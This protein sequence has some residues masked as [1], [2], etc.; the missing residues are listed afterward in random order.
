MNDPMAEKTLGTRRIFEGR[1]LTIDIVDIELPTGRTS[2]REILRHHG[3]VCILA[4]RPDGAF[5]LVNQY[6]KAVEKTLLECV[7]GCMEPGESPDSAALRETRE[8]SGYEVESLVALGQSLPAPGYC[9]EVHY[10]FYARLKPMAG[11]LQLDTDENLCPV[12]LTAEAIDSA[13]EDGTIDDGKTIILWN[14]YQRA[15]RRGIL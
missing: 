15:L 10:H 7:A 3:A 9:D 5:I 12:A 8:E 13:I 2:T 1:A 4:Q 6:R 14:F 11:A